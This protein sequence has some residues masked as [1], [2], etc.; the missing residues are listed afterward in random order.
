MSKDGGPVYSSLREAIGSTPI[1]RLNRITEGLPHPVFVKLEHL[2]PTG[3]GKDRLAI[4]VLDQ[5]EQSGKLKPGQPIVVP[6]SGNAAVSM[7]WAGRSRRHP[8]YAVIPKSASLEFRQLLALYGAGCELSPSEQGLAGARRRAVWLAVQHHALLWDPFSD[9][10]GSD[11]LRHFADEIASFMREQHVPLAAV[12]C[13]LGTGHT[14]AALHR[15]LPDVKVIA[16]EPVE[17]AAALGRESGPHKV[18]GIGVGF[19]T[20]RIRDLGETLRVELV[21][22]NNAWNTKRRL[23]REEGLFVGPTSGATVAAALVE[24]KRL[25][26]PV[27]AIAMDS[28]ERSFSLEA[29]VP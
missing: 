9:P 20:E 12:V 13:G 3:S 11:G 4:A 28:G 18:H 21:S 19:T 25:D 26:G 17:S 5:L 22:M 10:A 14:I 2:S 15:F 1:L 27:L 29:Q 6:S 23:A 24:V 16:V 8:V 7:A